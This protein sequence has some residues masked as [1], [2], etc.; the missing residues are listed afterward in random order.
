VSAQE[1]KA[2]IFDV[3]LCHNREDRPAVREIAQRLKKAG[4]KPWLDEDQIRPGTLW[5]TALGEQIENIKSVAVFVGKNGI[6]SWQDEEIQAFIG[7]FVDRGCPVIPT[8]LAD[9]TQTPKLPWTLRNRHCVD[10]RET[11]PEPL[12]QLVWA[13][14]GR[15]PA[16]AGKVALIAALNSDVGTFATYAHPGVYAR[17]VIP[18]DLCKIPY[19]VWASNGDPFSPAQ[20]KH[21][22]FASTDNQVQLVIDTRANSIGETIKAFFNAELVKRA[23]GGDHINNSVLKADWYVISGTNNLGFK[24]YKKF[25]ALPK[26]NIATDYQDYTP[27][28][29]VAFNFVYPYDQRKTYEPM[30]ATIDEGFDPGA[31]TNFGI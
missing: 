2:E 23:V 29:W 11:Y 13:I 20:W 5:Q 19:A 24:F 28:Y 1:F 16:E 26:V 7:E 3:I 8:V 25:Y 21:T 22:L 15:N 4:V 10:F 18:V 9:V 31:E 12:K 30:V 17:A 27:K 14:T 6:G